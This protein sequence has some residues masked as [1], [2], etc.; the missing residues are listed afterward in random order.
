MATRKTLSLEDGNLQNRS[1]INSRS[2]DFR[3][4]DLLFKPRPSGDIYKKTDA[5]AVKQSVLNIIMTNFYEK[6]FR[7]FFGSNLREQL[8]ELSDMSS[9]TA[10]KNT[11]TTALSNYETRIKIKSIE[12]KPNPSNNEVSIKLVFNIINSTDD[13]VVQTYVS[14]L[15]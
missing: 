7:P 9:T 10:I 3:D 15:R 5:A 4:I 12:V 6:P 13:L 14:R 1:I 8:F 2:N 11:I